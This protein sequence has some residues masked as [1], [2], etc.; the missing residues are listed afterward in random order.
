M[1]R[2]ANDDDR[3]RGRHILFPLVFLVLGFILA[4]S[5][6]MLGNQHEEESYQSPS[7][8]Q[9][10]RYREE[11]IEQQ[12]RNKELA[13]E[14]ASKQEVIRKAEQSFS[15]KE[16]NH[17]GLVEEAKDLRLL[18]G[19]VPAGGTGVKVTLKDADYNP[20]EQNPNDYIVHESHILRVINELRISG[21]QGLAING[22]RITS[23]SYIKC[24]GPVITIDG[25][26]FPAPFVIEAV[27]D[28]DVLSSALNLK[29]GVLDGLARENIVVTLE[30]LKDIRLPALR[31]ER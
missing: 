14:I 12:E 5:Y 18:L 10:E 24:T 27:G 31:N 22:Q 16:K 21:A 13:D 2:K 11:L 30:Q 4:F 26:T 15:E 3:K 28:A 1:K 7:L 25:R 20:V 29:G 6:R 17:E 23:N 8:L 9:E 19:A